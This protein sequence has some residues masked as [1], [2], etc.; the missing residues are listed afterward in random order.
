[1]RK[2]GDVILSG[3]L[4]C[5]VGATYFL[6]EV[7]YKTARGHPGGISWTMLVLAL[8]VGIILERMR[9]KIR[10]G[11]FPCSMNR[12]AQRAMCCIPAS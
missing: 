4:A 8:L 6:L 2:D 1:M 7:A 11:P 9:Q 3:L 12:C 5:F 10:R